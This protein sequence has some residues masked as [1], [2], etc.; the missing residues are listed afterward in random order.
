MNDHD[1]DD[2]I[3]SRLRNRRVQAKE[4]DL[5][6]AAQRAT[7]PASFFNEPEDHVETR[8]RVLAA[9]RWIVQT[10]AAPGRWMIAVPAS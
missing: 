6:A 1:L 7:S 10:A 8:I 9:D 3:L 5:S 2:L 4:G